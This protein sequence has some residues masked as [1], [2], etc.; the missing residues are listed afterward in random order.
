MRLTAIACN[1]CVEGGSFL[2]PYLR[3]FLKLTSHMLAIP[4][5]NAVNMYI[6]LNEYII[7]YTSMCVKRALTV[8]LSLAVT[9]VGMQVVHEEG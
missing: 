3:V 1:S 9:A 7:L 6:Q 2:P 8:E 5:Y 4:V